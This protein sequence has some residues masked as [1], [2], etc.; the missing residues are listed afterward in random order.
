MLV[1]V[2]T[3]LLLRL[4]SLLVVVENRGVVTLSV[5]ASGVCS[6]LGLKVD[7]LNLNWT[8]PKEIFKYINSPG[9]AC[10]GSTSRRFSFRNSVGLFDIGRFGRFL[11]EERSIFRRSAHSRLFSGQVVVFN[12]AGNGRFCVEVFHIYL[13]TMLLITHIWMNIET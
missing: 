11:S 9:I 12:Y 4:V 5:M 2:T 10:M 3:G 7:V 13:K 6:L 8:L 1:V